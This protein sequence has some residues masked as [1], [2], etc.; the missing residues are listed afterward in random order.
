LQTRPGNIGGHLEGSTSQFS[1]IE[2]RSVTTELPEFYIL[3]TV[4]PEA[5]VD[6]QPT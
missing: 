5:I 1:G 4:H 2:K 6:F 3:L